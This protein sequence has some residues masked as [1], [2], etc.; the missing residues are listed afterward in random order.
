MRDEV[1]TAVSMIMMK[2]RVLAQ[3]TAAG[4]C[5]RFA[6]TYCFHHHE[7]IFIF[8]PENGDFLHS[9]DAHLRAYTQEAQAHTVGISER[10][11]YE[12]NEI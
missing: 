9:V 7:S 11:N 8:N 6:E 10:G 12:N 5:R 2:I 1:F 4:T 3:S